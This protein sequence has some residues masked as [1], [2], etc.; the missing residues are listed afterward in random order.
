MCPGFQ[1]EVLLRDSVEGR[2]VADDQ[3]NVH[4]CLSVYVHQ[5]GTGE[6]SDTWMDRCVD[7]QVHGWTGVWMDRCVDGQMH[8]Q[9]QA[10]TGRWTDT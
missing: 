6:W 2:Q 3:K 4:D 9:M 1:Q 5:Q 8:R 10:L 7:G